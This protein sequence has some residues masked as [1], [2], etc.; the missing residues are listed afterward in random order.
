MEKTAA[1]IKRRFYLSTG[2]ALFISLACSI[3]AQAFFGIPD[4][5][6]LVTPPLAIILLYT[7]SAIA[8]RI[9]MKVINRK[10]EDIARFYMVYQL[11]KV[12]ASGMIAACGSLLLE[13]PYKKPF[14][15]LFAIAFFLSLITES[16]S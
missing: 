15:I 2:L 16:Y 10:P 5:L 9:Y 12:V 4:F 14:V 8:L 1:N 13:T 11:L 6:H 3:S 7:I